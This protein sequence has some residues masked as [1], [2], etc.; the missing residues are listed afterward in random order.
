MTRF[1]RSVTLVHR[2]EEFRASRIML[3]R[4]KANDKITF[5]TNKAV[6]AVEG[7]D[8]VTGLRLRDTVTGEESTL[9]VSGVFVAIGHD[10]RS[11]LV[12]DVVETDPDGYVLVKAAPP[13]PPSRACSPPGTWWI[14]PTAKPSPPP[15]ADARPPSTPNAGSPTTRKRTWTHPSH[16]LS[17]DSR[18]VTEV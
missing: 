13:A 2:R 10:P 15:A 9:A 18:C 3:E 6:E 12:R 17:A 11:E 5:L 7:A 16:R 4:A 14:A 1:A 8:T